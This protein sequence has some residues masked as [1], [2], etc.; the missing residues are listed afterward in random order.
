MW[1]SCVTQVHS[2]IRFVFALQVR[3]PVHLIPDLKIIQSC[4]YYPLS[5][6]ESRNVLWA[7][8]AAFAYICTYAIPTLHSFLALLFSPRLKE[9]HNK[10]TQIY[11]GWVLTYTDGTHQLVCYLFLTTQAALDCFKVWHSSMNS[12]F[13]DMQKGFKRGMGRKCN[14]SIYCEV[15][16][17]AA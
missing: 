12:E 5:Y 13:L 9:R 10:A 14:V 11:I 3:Q 1:Y 8:L 17:K 7:L 16:R 4:L 6:F 2:Q 15:L